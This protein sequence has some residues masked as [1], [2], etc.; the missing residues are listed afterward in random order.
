MIFYNFPFSSRPEHLFSLMKKRFF[1]HSDAIEKLQ[2]QTPSYLQ[3]LRLAYHLEHLK[4]SITKM[5][6][7]GSKIDTNYFNLNSSE[8]I[9]EFSRV[10]E[11][12]SNNQVS[13]KTC[14][15]AMEKID[16]KNLKVNRF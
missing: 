8:N 3:K 2:F 6:L 12:Y 13:Q 4:I 11:A 1:T 10:C 15:N 14:Y 16:W 9:V 7:W 5:K